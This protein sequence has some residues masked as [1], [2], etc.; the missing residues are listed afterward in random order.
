MAGAGRCRLFDVKI[1]AGK[2][3]GDKFPYLTST[4]QEIWLT[5]PPGATPGQPK[6]YYTTTEL[7]DATAQ[8]K[9]FL[10]EVLKSMDCIF[11]K[12]GVYRNMWSLTNFSRS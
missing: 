7:V 3:A 2:A 12:A 4:R 10:R 11:H 6:A 8:P 5:V 1:P 9:D